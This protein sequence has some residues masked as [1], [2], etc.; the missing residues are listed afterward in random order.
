M[1]TLWSQDSSIQKRLRL[2][3]YPRGEGEPPTGALGLPGGYVVNKWLSEGL[4]AF[5]LIFAKDLCL[6]LVT[7][8]QS[9]MSETIKVK[10]K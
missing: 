3:T 5:Q 7:R 6:Y 10:L 4:R 1:V 2:S 8:A 9:P